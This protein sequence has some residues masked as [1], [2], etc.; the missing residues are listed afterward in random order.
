[1]A[2]SDEVLWKIQG[3][4]YIRIDT[5][6]FQW[7]EGHEFYSAFSTENNKVKYLHMGT[8]SKEKVPFFEHVNLQLVLLGVFHLLFLIV[9]FFAF[10]QFKKKGEH[11]YILAGLGG[12]M[13]F[14][15][16]PI[17]TAVLFSVDFQELYKGATTVMI[18]A[19]WI[20][21]SGGLV[22]LISLIYNRRQKFIF[23]LMLA[24]LLYIPYLIYWNFPILP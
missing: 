23:W 5:L 12:L 4:K 11:V 18:I 15:A 20:T 3:G 21:F 24:S 19:S 16:L 22:M 2:K 7:H 14:V 1:M 9:T 8:G 10:Y 6:L 17:F 13:F